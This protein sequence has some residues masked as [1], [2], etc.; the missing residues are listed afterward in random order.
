MRIRILEGDVRRL[1][2]ENLSLRTELIQTKCQLARQSQSSALIDGARNAQKALEKVIQEIAGIKN[3]LEGS[4]HRGPISLRGSDA[5]H[6]GNPDLSNVS[7]RG[8]KKTV[9]ERRRMDLKFDEFNEE[10]KNKQKALTSGYL[11]II[12][13]D[14]RLEAP[15]S[16]SPRVTSETDASDSE[17]E[18]I[19][20]EEI[21][22]SEASRNQNP[23][24]IHKD[25]PPTPSISH[26]TTL[27][28]P[29]REKPTTPPPPPK[30]NPRK[31]RRSELFATSQGKENA[32]ILPPTSD[33]FSP[34]IT[35]TGRTILGESSPPRPSLIIPAGL[36]KL[37]S[38]NKPIQKVVEKDVEFVLHGFE[39]GGNRRASRA[40][41]VVNYALPNLRDK[42]RRE[43]SS[44]E[45]KSRGRSR[46][47]DR[48]VTPDRVVCSSLIKY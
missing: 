31:R 38:P 42:M 37:E 1:M 21:N 24:A 34:S 15:F 48:S 13:A 16:G 46:S 40:R 27:K 39:E 18:D 17:T 45:N 12:S 8:V 22:V 35:Q 23:L 29:L 28:H 41:K 3:G 7:S 6:S 5:V 36:T 14:N 4:L 47:I 9:K 32:S 2:D 30:E 26:R 10:R 20:T 33:L 19:L 43:D 11:L 25:N 44:E